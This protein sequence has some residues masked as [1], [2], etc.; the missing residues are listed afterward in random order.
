MANSGVE[1]ITPKVQPDM[2]GESRA[3]NLPSAP[4][5]HLPWGMLPSFSSRQQSSPER[6]MADQGPRAHDDEDKSQ[7][8]RQERT[9]S[10]WERRSMLT[11]DRTE[12]RQKLSDKKTVET[13]DKE[14]AS[15]TSRDKKL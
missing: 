12:Q 5:L 10:A 7:Q 1:N 3:W 15:R 9:P 11:E 14:P 2:S 13:R 6:V 4:T 8:P